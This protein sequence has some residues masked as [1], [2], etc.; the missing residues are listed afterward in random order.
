MNA[1]QQSAS[2]GTIKRNKNIGGNDY[3]P[4]RENR[5]IK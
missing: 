1:L 4:S 2:C 5:R 3:E